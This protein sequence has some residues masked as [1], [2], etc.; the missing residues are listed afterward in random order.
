MAKFAKIFGFAVVLLLAAH[1][2]GAQHVS[3]AT[4]C[5]SSGTLVQQAN[6][7]CLPASS[8]SQGNVND[9]LL[10]VINLLL[11]VC[12]IIAVLFIVWGGF[13]Y[14]TSNGNEEGAKKGMKIVTDA[15]I[16]LAIIILAFVIV[17]VV[18]NTASGFA[19]S[20]TGSGSGI[21]FSF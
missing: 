10:Q 18:V 15:A 16:G 4:N 5:G 1:L 17:T 8:A 3:A 11:S 19:G 12:A 13:R 9:F 20:G 6:G 21:G 2:F 14:I 7:L